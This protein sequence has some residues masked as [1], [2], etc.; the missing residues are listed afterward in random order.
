MCLSFGEKKG[1]KGMNSKGLIFVDEIGNDV[2][3]PA[4]TIELDDVCDKGRVCGEGF[5]QETRG[6]KF[7]TNAS[8]DNRNLIMKH[9]TD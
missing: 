5:D 1:S 3:K 6:E 7:S 4:L 2:W 9:G 8:R